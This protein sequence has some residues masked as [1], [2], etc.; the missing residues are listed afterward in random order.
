VAMVVFA[1]SKQGRGVAGQLVVL[2]QLIRMMD[3]LHEAHQAR[4]QARQAIALASVSRNQ[5]TQL[6]RNLTARATP[7]SAIGSGS[8]SIAAIPTPGQPPRMPNS[9]PR[10]GT[11]FGR[12]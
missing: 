2:R 12:G 9:P 4:G 7:R 8:G 10:S 11:D 1:G 3:T 5:L 6:H